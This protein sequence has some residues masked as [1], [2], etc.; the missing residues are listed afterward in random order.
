MHTLAATQSLVAVSRRGGSIAP[1]T[2]RFSSAI[3][4]LSGLESARLLIPEVDAALTEGWA[5]NPHMFEQQV[6]QRKP[7]LEIDRRDF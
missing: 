1:P 5:V 6:A 3:V 2:W 7:V 4:A